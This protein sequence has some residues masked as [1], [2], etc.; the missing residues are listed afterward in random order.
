MLR[1]C[2]IT[3]GILSSWDASLTGCAIKTCDAE[4]RDRACPVSTRGCATYKRRF[5]YNNE[6]WKIK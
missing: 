6:Y 3:D 1:S 5:F 4:C 2:L